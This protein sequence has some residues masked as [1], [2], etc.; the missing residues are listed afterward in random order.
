MNYIRSHFAVLVLASS[1]LTLPA[2][3][4]AQFEFTINN[5][6]ITITKYTGP[7]GDVVIPDTIN[8][9]PVTSLWGEFS[10]SLRGAF[11]K[12]TN[13]TS[14]VIPNSVTNIGACAFAFC[15]GLTS[16]L[17][18]EKVTYIG[19]AAFGCCSNL[20][21]ITVPNSVTNISAYAFDSCTSLTS[22]TIGSNV[23]YIGYGALRNCPRL[24]SVA[25]PDSVTSIG[26]EA[27]M[28]CTGLTNVTFGNG[29]TST[30]NEAFR[31]CDSLTSVT[32]G[33]NVTS[34]GGSA[35]ADCKNLNNVMIGN[36][37]T[38]IGNGA[39]M[40]CIRLTSVTMGNSVISIGYGAFVG[41]SLTSITVPESVISIEAGA[42]AG[43]RGVYFLGDAIGL[44]AEKMFWFTGVPPLYTPTV[45]YLP[46]RAG[47]G[48][49]F[50]GCPTALWH[51][52]VADASATESWLL[53]ANGL[54][55]TAVL[56]GSRSYDLDGGS[57]QYSWFASGSLLGTGVMAETV[58]PVGTHTVD[59]VVS[60][61]IAT[62]TNSITVSVVSSGQAVELL[63]ALVDSSAVG[64]PKPLTASLSAA[65]A[66]IE[67]GNRGAA[68]N[69]LRAFQSKVQ[70]QVSDTVLAQQFIEAARQVI[71]AL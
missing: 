3:V 28:W 65:K 33:N 11:Y 6:T 21:S 37:V 30:G 20:T 25:I 14:V 49:T 23:T 45:Y 52:P 59:L 38:N 55:A 40:R 51:L 46:G 34:I 7:G 36:S 19:T 8:G 54:N 56:D 66:S 32:I 69:Q 68:A 1:L 31:C 12:C 27:L 4:Q 29:V 2:L 5:G 17:I 53:S 60:D 41:C 9:L 35:F 61:G 24:N 64:K 71:E 48:P 13:L 57:L 70:V 18:P 63:I 47:W 62:S 44:H 42:F 10:Y 67:R 26:E 58:L 22:I 50:D 39:F 16:V 15:S 43:L